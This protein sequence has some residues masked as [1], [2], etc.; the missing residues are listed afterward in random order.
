MTERRWRLLTALLGVAA[1]VVLIHQV[2][3][4]RAARG[5]SG[6]EVSEPVPVGAV[7]PRFND[8]SWSL[9]PG[10]LW[11]QQ[12]SSSQWYLRARIEPGARLVATHGPGGPSVLLV[13]GQAPL[14]AQAEGHRCEGALPAVGAELYPLVFE[15]TQ[16][17]YIFRS[18]KDRIACSA[19]GVAD[20]QPILQVSG[21][22]VELASI[23]AEE[24]PAGVPM[25]ALGWLGGI[26]VGGLVWMV[27]LEWER[28]RRLAWPGIILTG[29]PSLVG[30]LLLWLQPA[31]QL[32]SVSV[33]VLLVMGSVGLKLVSIGLGG[34]QA[35]GQEE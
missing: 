19:A 26:A 18:A 8:S 17:G 35:R 3:R 31:A 20:A 10:A 1:A 4:Y 2:E 7:A 30:L 33:A 16:D 24:W 28:F 22:R 27:L 5:P 12:A 13:R 29:L 21:G 6:W 9:A 14:P 32:G 23:G 15:R 25:S 11:T 34:K